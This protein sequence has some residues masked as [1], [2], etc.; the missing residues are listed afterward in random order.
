M[1]EILNESVVD[2][3]GIASSEAVGSV[4]DKI[5]EKGWLVTISGILL[6]ILAMAF[7]ALL[8][9]VISYFNSRPIKTVKRIF[10]HSSGREISVE[11]KDKITGETACAIA[12]AIH[13]YLDEASDT[14]N[15]VVTIARADKAYSPWSSKI[16]VTNRN[17]FRSRKL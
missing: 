2:I 8:F 10:D 15:T 1:N 14:E 7:L 11:V 6:V 13:M 4:L 5:M 9:S 16:Y 12:A 17:V 3:A